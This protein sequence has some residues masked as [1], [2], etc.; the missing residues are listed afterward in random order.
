[1]I[2]RTTPTTNDVTTNDATKNDATT[3][4]GYN[5]HFLSIKSRC[6]NE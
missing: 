3:N 6:Y 1:M 4:E 2:Q 5:E